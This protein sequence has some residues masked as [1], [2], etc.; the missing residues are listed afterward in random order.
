MHG[1][2]ISV[3]EPEEARRSSE[4]DDPLLRIAFLSEV[5]IEL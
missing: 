2:F 3:G 4:M 5:S 1:V